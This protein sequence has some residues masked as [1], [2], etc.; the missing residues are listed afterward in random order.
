MKPIRRVSDPHLIAWALAIKAFFH[1]KK[2][3]REIAEETGLN[4]N[5]VCR[6]AGVLHQVGIAYVT[7]LDLDGHNKPSI[8]VFKLGEDDD[9]E[10]VGTPRTQRAREQRRRERLRKPLPKGVIRA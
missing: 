6:Y 2:T 10:V 7:R 3:N 8:R 1:G 9:V 5:S 4:Y